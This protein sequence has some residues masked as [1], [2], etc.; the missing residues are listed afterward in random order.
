MKQEEI[1]NINTMKK[2]NIITLCSGYDAMVLALKR[3]R[4]DFPQFKFDLLA[5]S[6]I[7]S[8][9]CM[10]HN[11]LHP[12]FKDRA[13]GDMT[14]VDWQCFRQRRFDERR[15]RM[16][17][18]QVTRMKRIIKKYIDD[19]KGDLFFDESTDKD[20]QRARQKLA[21][22]EADVEATETRMK[23]KIQQ[24]RENK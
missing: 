3:L 11:A 19:R 23:L 1:T 13:V 18:A 12:E 22:K 21:R 2:N 20:L 14:K 5:W 10:A 6:E 8:Y 24:I 4:K 15:R 16:S 17:K 9:A 7:D